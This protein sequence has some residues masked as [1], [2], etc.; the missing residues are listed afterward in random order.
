MEHER[1]QELER[2]RD[3]LWDY[4]LLLCQKP[5]LTA[6]HPKADG[7]A[8]LLPP[9]RKTLSQLRRQYQSNAQLKVATME[10]Q[11]D[12][13]AATLKGNGNG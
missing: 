7:Q 1:V 11:A 12:R 8:Q 3:G 6:V 5:P 9:P 2:V 10:E 4:V 13:F